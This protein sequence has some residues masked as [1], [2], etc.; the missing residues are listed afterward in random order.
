MAAPGPPR[1]F[2]TLLTNHALWADPQPDYGQIVALVGDANIA[3]DAV[4]RSV[5]NIAAR[6]PTALVMVLTGDTDHICVG[7]SP[8]LYPAQPGQATGMD[9]L[10]ITLVGR[11]A[12]AIAPVALPADA[13][14]RSICSR[15]KSFQ[16]T[17]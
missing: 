9:D 2:H 4:L 6:S 17:Y 3:R 8:F 5:L 16:R 15:W 1:D 11:M 13:F 12:D 14:A 10:A 7:H